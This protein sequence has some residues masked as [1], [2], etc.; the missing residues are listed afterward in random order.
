MSFYKYVKQFKDEHS[1]IGDFA[2]DMV[3]DETFPKRTV[4][5]SKIKDYLE[6]QCNACSGAMDAF[7][8]AFN[9]YRKECLLTN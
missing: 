3:D 1:L 5:Y 9:Q 6:S 8:K 4:D 2:Y 7:E